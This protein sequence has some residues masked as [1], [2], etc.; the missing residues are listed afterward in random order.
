MLIKP[1]YRWSGHQA[2]QYLRI[3]VDIDGVR[4]WR[5]YSL[6]SDPYRPDGLISVTVK[7]VEEGKVS[8]HL[9]RRAVPGIIVGLGGVEGDFV[10]PDPPPAQAA[11]RQRRQ[12]HHADHEHAPP[13]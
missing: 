4:H 8:S 1:G 13:P 12:R 5:A 9:V 7:G 3:G 11:V 2:G 6:T 10:L